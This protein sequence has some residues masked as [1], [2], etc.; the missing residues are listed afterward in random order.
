[1]ELSRR[2]EWMHIG[3]VLVKE[4]WTMEHRRIAQIPQHRFFMAA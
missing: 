4:D 1:M 3:H 2:G